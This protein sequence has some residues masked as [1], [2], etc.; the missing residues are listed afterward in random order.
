LGG[1]GDDHF[2]DWDWGLLHRY[3]EEEGGKETISSLGC[4]REYITTLYEA[5]IDH[6]LPSAFPLV[7]ESEYLDLGHERSHITSSCRTSTF[8]KS[9]T[10]TEGL[11]EKMKIAEDL[12]ATGHYSWMRRTDYSRWSWT[13]IVPSLLA[14]AGFDLVM[15]TL[16]GSADDFRQ[17]L[18]QIVYELIDRMPCRNR[19]E[20]AVRTNANWFGCDWIRLHRQRAWGL[21]DPNERVGPALPAGTEYVPTLE[22]AAPLDFFEGD[23]LEWD[24]DDWTSYWIRASWA[25]YVT[26]SICHVGGVRTYESLARRMSPFW[27]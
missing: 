7:E 24:D 25:R 16:T 4:V 26:E 8:N 11:H 27:L 14:S 10:L 9:C 3:R 12:M 22:K 21:L 13:D 2:Q 6:S 19:V 18:V 20:S 17:L 15:A 1:I 5:M 23:G